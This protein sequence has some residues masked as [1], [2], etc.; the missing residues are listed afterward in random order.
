VKFPNSTVLERA[1][2]AEATSSF[3]RV[4]ATH[5]RLTH[6]AYLKPLFWMSFGV[7]AIGANDMGQYRSSLLS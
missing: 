3:S 2:A 7:P 1:P 5:A 4:Y 6:N